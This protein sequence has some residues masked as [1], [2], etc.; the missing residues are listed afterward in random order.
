VFFVDQPYLS[1]FFKKT[2]KDHAIPVVDTAPSREM[3]LL[4]GTRLISEAEAVERAQAPDAPPIYTTSENA[5]G[6]ITTHL[7]SGDLPEKVDLFKDKARFRRLLRPLF[8][9]FYF[10]EI[11]IEDAAKL[12]VGELPFPLIIKPTVGFMSMGVR[13]VSTPAEWVGA[14]DS[15]EQELQRI[16]GL[17]PEHVVGSQSFIV[18][19]CVPGEEFAVDAYFDAAGNPVVLGIFK[20]L[21]S[22]EAD[23]SDRVYVTSKEMIECHLDE[24]TGFIGEIGRLAGVKNFAVHVELR[25]D[26]E[27]TLF[28][29]EVNPM[30]FGGWCTT[31]DLAFHAYGLNPY[32]CY[33]LQEQPDWPMLLDGKAGRIFSLMVLENSTGIVG[34][35]VQ[36]FDYEKMCSMLEN[37]L[38]LRKIDFREYPVFGFL[39]AETRK[40]RE[41][42]LKNMLTLDLSEFVSIK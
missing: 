8:P 20:H 15:I 1:D 37:P 12:R 3:G 11:Q 16:K 18:E 42:E 40:G 24:F 22:S 26:S 6:W 32:L 14:V 31:A 27:G 33:Y 30:R 10:K 5:L 34:E 36:S 41:D 4:P 25:R 17:Y 29:V 35:R 7:A 21:F 23:L 9:D 39:F 28:P 13:K 2:V 19:A 38:E